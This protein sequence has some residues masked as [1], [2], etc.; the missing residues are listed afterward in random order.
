[1]EA[2]ATIPKPMLQMVGKLT[3]VS[4]YLHASHLTVKVSSRN[5][6]DFFFFDNEILETWTQSV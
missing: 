1:M 2:C 4:L 3:S 5:L 6:R